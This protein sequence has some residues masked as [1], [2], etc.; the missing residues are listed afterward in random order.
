MRAKLSVGVAGIGLLVLAAV[1]V[2]AHHAFTA[3]FDANK[4]IKLRG[5]VV[6]MEWINPHSWLTLDVKL[7]DGTAERWEI[8]A[9]APNSMFRRGFTKES[10]PIGSEIVV[11]G[12]QA[13]DGKMRGN[14]RDLTF[15]DGRTLFIG[16]AGTPG[17]PTQKK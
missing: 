6:K 12:Y 13:K 9:G 15:A 17:A 14:G 8:E 5:T 16:T 10:L 4:P 7:P 3:E 1:P 2:L 11:S